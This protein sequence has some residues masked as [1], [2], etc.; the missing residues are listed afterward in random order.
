MNLVERVQKTIERENLLN[1]RQQTIVGL[2]GGPDSMAL[3]YCLIELGYLCV[4]VH[5]NFNLRGK[6]SCRD[7]S[8]VKSY[9]KENGIKLIVKSF[10]TVK[11]AEENKVSIEM[12][13]R[14]LRYDY[15]EE[16]RLNEN[17]QGIAVAHHR[18]DNIETILLN[19][20]RGTGI[21][22]LSGMKYRNDSNIIRPMLDISRDEIMSFLESRRI[23]YVI[24]HTNLE[25]IVKRNIIRLNVLPLFRR[26][27]PSVEKA[28]H[29]TGRY[30]SEVSSIY[31]TTIQEKLHLCLNKSPLDYVYVNISDLKKSKPYQPILYEWLN[32]Y[33]FN[34]IQLSEV[35]SAIN[36]G[37]ILSLSAE[38]YRLY[39]G[40]KFLVLE[41]LDNSLREWEMV[42]EDDGKYK[43][44]NGK[45]LLMRSKR[46]ILGK[47]KIV[48]SKDFAYFDAD[49]IKYPFKL[50]YVMERDRFHP[51][52]MKGSQL[53]SDYLTN[54]KIAVYDKKKQLV[55]ESGMD[56]LWIVGK[57]TSQKAMITSKTQNVKILS[58]CDR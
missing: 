2:S 52:G 29:N 10:D 11:Y 17:A 8:F 53:I 28:V 56:I 24:D 47:S 6:E 41:E 44:P 12:A 54:K 48:K 42:L 45:A 34:S 13:A 30:L 14:N 23:P 31:K 25:P 46:W 39:V 7:E 40:D 21:R 9:C 58:I 19:L 16:V 5:C 3:L 33:G 51:Y 22:G 57:R 26:L 15:F 4:A 35:S 37:N 43:L 55:L 50:R 38:R 18:D 49:I 32:Q 36:Q 1:I 27:N 20:V